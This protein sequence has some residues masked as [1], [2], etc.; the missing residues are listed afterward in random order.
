MRNQL[1]NQVHLK[2]V[3][4]ELRKNTTSA[5][6][7]LWMYLRNKQLDGRKFR[8]QFFIGNF[9][10]DL[11]C[12]SEKLAIEL[13]GKSHYDSIG[14]SNDERKENFLKENGIVVLRFENKKIFS[15]PERVLEEIKMHFAQRS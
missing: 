2:Q 7:T 13:D 15:T 10:V 11:Y 12:P 1:Y 4:Q 8:R 3:R 9:V 14:L 5:E 6:G